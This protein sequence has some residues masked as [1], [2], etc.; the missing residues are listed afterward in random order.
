M[1]TSRWHEIGPLASLAVILTLLTLT[2]GASLFAP[3]NE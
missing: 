2:L 3:A 1:L